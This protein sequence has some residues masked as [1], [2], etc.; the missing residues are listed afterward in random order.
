[1]KV[2]KKWIVRGIVSAALKD[3]VICDVNSYTVFTDV[4]QFVKWIHGIIF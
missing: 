2:N 1:M 4:A 3:G